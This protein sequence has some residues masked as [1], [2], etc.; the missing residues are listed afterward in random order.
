[1]TVIFIESR[2]YSVTKFLGPSSSNTP[3]T[4][5]AGRGLKP[6]PKI[7]LFFFRINAGARIKAL[8]ISV[9]KAPY[10]WATQTLRADTLCA[11]KSVHRSPQFST[12]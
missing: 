1:L 6:P 8:G 12:D 10:G 11:E 9:A 7:I 2:D 5:K 4:P 3:Y